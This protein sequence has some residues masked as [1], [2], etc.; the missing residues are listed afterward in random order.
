M[1]VVMIDDIMIRDMV[2]NRS[3]LFVIL[4][5][6]C[7]GDFYEPRLAVDLLNKALEAHGLGM[8]APVSPVLHNFV[9]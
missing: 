8:R 5:E 2:E 1:D 7:I 9:S 4:F 6:D 3:M